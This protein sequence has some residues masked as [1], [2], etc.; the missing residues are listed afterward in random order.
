MTACIIMHKMILEDER[1]LGHIESPYES[2]AA[3]TWHFVSCAATSDFVSFV[4]KH[5][6]I[7]DS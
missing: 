7:H 1:D 5:E 4:K 2:G 6:E 3:E